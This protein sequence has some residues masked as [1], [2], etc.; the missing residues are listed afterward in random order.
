M[1]DFLASMLKLSIFI[2]RLSGS[3]VHISYYFKGVIGVLFW[4]M[5]FCCDV[6]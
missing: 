1:G 4:L 5:M 2:L 3:R 6:L